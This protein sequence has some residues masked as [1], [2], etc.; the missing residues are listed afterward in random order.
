MKKAILFILAAAA[1]YGILYLLLWLPPIPC[2]ALSV[3]AILVVCKVN[4]DAE[5]MGCILLVLAMAAM[6]LVMAN[7]ICD[8]KTAACYPDGSLG[9]VS[10]LYPFFPIRYSTAR[11]VRIEK[12]D[13]SQNLVSGFTYEYS[14]DRCEPEKNNDVWRLEKANGKYDVVVYNSLKGTLTIV[15][16]ADSLRVIERSYAAGNVHGVS[17]CKNAVWRTTDLFG[18]DMEAPGYKP[19]LRAIVP[20]DATAQ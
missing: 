12:L 9:L 5:F 3:I 6:A 17:Y 1:L 20:V 18:E 2:M 16:D 15:A 7:G 19:K 14:P 10:P 4:E 8:R 11:A 13:S